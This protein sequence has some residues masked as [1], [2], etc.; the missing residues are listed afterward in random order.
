MRINNIL[1]KAEI[2]PGLLLGY[3]IEIYSGKEMVL[4]GNVE[5]MDLSD[6]IIKLKI[7]DKIISFIGKNLKISCYTTDGIKINGSFEQIV[8]NQGGK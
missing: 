8:F 5:I 4:S 2:P 3:N 6:T 7:N 1:K